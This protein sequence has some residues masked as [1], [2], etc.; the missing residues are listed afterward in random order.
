MP[1]FQ[2]QILATW[3]IGGGLWLAGMVGLG[4]HTGAASEDQACSTD[5]VTT[6]A[7][8]HT[9]ISS[10]YQ[11]PSGKCTVSLRSVRLAP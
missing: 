5:A 1:F 7:F 6:A 2:R 3:V 9:G 8:L 10:T 4:L 11:T